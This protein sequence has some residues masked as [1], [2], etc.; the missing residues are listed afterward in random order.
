MAQERQESP[1]IPLKFGPQRQ[2]DAVRKLFQDSGYTAKAVCERLG[3]GSVFELENLESGPMSVEGIDSA[4]DALIWLFVGGELLERA[5]A[6]RFLSD[7]DLES[8]ATLGLL[9]A[10]PS[11]TAVQATVV[12]SPVE[13]VYVAS[14]L[15]INRI[16]GSPTTFSD[17]VYPPITASAGWFLS[18]LPR[19][20]CGSF[21]ELCGGTGIA[22]LL[23]ATSARQV[24]AVDITTRS[25]VFAA[26]NAALNQVAGF[27]ALEGDLYEPVGHETF[28][29]IVAHPPYMPAAEN[30]RIFRDGGPDGEEITRRILRGLADHLRPGGRLYLTAILSD[31]RGALVQSRVREMLGPSESEFDVAVVAIK[32][33]HPIEHYGGELWK[34][35]ATAAEVGPQL[36][37]LRTLGIEG[38]LLCTLVVQRPETSRPVFTTRRLA[39][40]QCNAAALERLLRWE[41]KVT[42][43]NLDEW[44]GTAAP[45]SLENSE[46]LVSHRMD[47]GGWKPVGLELRIDGPFRE[48]LACGAWVAE[49]LRRCDGKR[50]ALSVLEAMKSDG[51]VPADASETEF[52]AMVKGLTAGGFLRF[53]DS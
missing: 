28:D 16:D 46:L 7:G 29:R 11:G 1:P 35:T 26:F 12:V 20:P 44:L 23:A 2:F 32:G 19:T 40:P 39:G 6:R 41:E 49:F 36:S 18:M 5:V 37:H 31:R 38:M 42:D 34:G 25:T 14:D 3:V 8:L 17:A 43:P 21:L 24:C 10:T 53:D 9:E 45:R 52:I 27:R 33:L 30:A 13:S 48:G 50:P 51:A 22:A 47:S 4:A 15:A